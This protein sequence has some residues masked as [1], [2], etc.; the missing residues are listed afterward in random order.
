MTTKTQL[1][2]TRRRV[3]VTVTLQPQ[4]ETVAETV[5]RLLAGRPELGGW[6][7]ILDIRNPH[8]QATA[9]ELDEI[10][11][12]FNARTSK[13]AYTVFVS[14]DPATYDRCALLGPKFHHRC[15]LVARD[16]AEAETLLPQTMQFI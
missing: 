8:Q 1:D 4:T 12:A 5:L 9:D 6:D 3:L 15:H 7:W 13:Q 11:A 2:N 14:R 10:A 16:V